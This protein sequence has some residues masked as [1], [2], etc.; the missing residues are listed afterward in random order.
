MLCYRLSY[1]GKLSKLRKLF[2]RSVPSCN[3]IVLDLIDFLEEEWKDIIFF[4]DNLYASR[5]SMYCNAISEKTGGIAE[6]ISLFIDGTKAAI[7]RPSSL[8]RL[9]QNL[10]NM[11]VGIAASIQQ[12]C[13]SGHKRMHCLN[14]QGIVAPDG[15]K[16]YWKTAI[17]ASNGF[18]YRHMHF[19][20]WACRRQAPRHYN[21]SPEWHPGVHRRASY[22]ATTRN[23]HLWGSRLWKQRDHV[24]SIYGRIFG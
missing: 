5:H 19:V 11:D 15:R 21:V 22:F 7:C 20:F 9:K 10:D 17:R 13:Y 23:V 8:Q 16:C 3:R 24:F 1:P 12:V 18:N 2:C 6:G 4:N 14:Y